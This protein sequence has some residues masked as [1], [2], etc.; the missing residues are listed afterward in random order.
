MSLKEVVAAYPY[1]LF[2]KIMNRVATNDIGYPDGT[3]DS[4]NHREIF[5]PSVVSLCVLL[6]LIVLW[7][8]EMNICAVDV[9]TELARQLFSKMGYSH[10]PEVSVH[11]VCQDA[12]YFVLMF[13]DSG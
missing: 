7:T 2:L 8:D 6:S 1:R 4:L 11:L 13:L 3:I 10:R 5:G 9:D 12:F